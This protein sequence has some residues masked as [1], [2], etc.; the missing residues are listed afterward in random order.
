MPNPKRTPRPRPDPLA[1]LVEAAVQR[2]AGKGSCT[3]DSLGIRDQRYARRPLDGTDGYHLWSPIRGL[4]T[5]YCSHWRSH[6]PNSWREEELTPPV[7]A[8]QIPPDQR[9]GNWKSPRY[10]PRPWI[11][12]LPE[13]WPGPKIPRWYAWWRLHDLQDGTCA[14]CDAPAYAIDHDHNTGL[15][16]GLLCVSCNHRE[17]MCSHRAQYGKHP[18][19]PCF[20]TYWDHPPAGPL[21]WMYGKSSLS[22]V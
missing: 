13:Q 11:G 3:P 20:Q 14:T 1:A 15:V 21:H 12:P 9:C 10:M 6:G 22:A 4:D 19:V 8:T 5:A 18:G 7:P 17:G 2:Q 16:R